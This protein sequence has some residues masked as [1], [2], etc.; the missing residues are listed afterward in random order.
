MITQDV[1]TTPLGYLKTGV[2]ATRK[3]TD[4]TPVESGFVPAAETTGKPR[5]RVPESLTNTLKD[6]VKTLAPA[7]PVVEEV[8]PYQEIEADTR[9]AEP[10]I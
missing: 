2:T 6:F 9:M 8:E 5:T 1:G 10:E 7:S 3:V 4:S